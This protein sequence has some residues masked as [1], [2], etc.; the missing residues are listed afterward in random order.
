MAEQDDN[1]KSVGLEANR[2]KM[3]AVEAPLL[4]WAERWIRPADHLDYMIRRLVIP[5]P[6][7]PGTPSRGAIGPAP[8]SEASV[9]SNSRLS[10]FQVAI[11]QYLRAQYD[12]LAQPIP[13]R[14]VELL[15]QLAQRH[16]GSEGAARAA[17]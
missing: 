3:F 5:V 10:E 1:R 2:A 9:R 15:G 16:S 12:D 14:L 6:S 13:A 11:G 8:H 7:F 4:D 17:G